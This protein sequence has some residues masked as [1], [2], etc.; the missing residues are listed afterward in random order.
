MSW[1]PEDFAMFRHNI[2]APESKVQSGQEN[3]TAFLQAAMRA[4]LQQILFHCPSN[5]H[6]SDTL[7]C[8]F[9]LYPK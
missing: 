6:L 1:V 9:S 8:L 4:D 7:F 2:W 5:L 3:S